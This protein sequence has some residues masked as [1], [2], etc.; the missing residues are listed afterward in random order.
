MICSASG[1]SS[2]EGTGKSAKEKNFDTL[3]NRIEEAISLVKITRN[4]N[5]R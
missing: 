2:S 3:T 1:I 4:T 5:G